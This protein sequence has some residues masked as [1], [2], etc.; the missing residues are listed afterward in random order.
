M[1]RNT[2][3]LLRRV[4]IVVGLP[5]VV[6]YATTVLYVFQG[7]E[8]N[9]QLPADCAMVFGTAVWPVRDANGEVTGAVAGP[10]IERRVGAAVDLV[11]QGSVR[12]LL[13]SGGKGEGNRTSEAEVMRS[14]ALA[15]GMSPSIITVE[16][17]SR[18]TWENLLFTRP[19]TSECASVV[20]IS[21]GY[22]L[23]RIAL[24]AHRQGWLQLQTYP[25]ADRPGFL[26][27]AKSL[28]REAVGI[29]VLVLSSLS[30]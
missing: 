7:M 12:R 6:F 9:A 20:A 25:A 27:M 13:L 28:L 26:F 21:D 1:T 30:R 5:I 23:A 14:V 16:D 2:L 8:G 24:Y 10:G 11:K 22:H 19:L 18:S 15:Q 4:L 29:D 3:S 17:R